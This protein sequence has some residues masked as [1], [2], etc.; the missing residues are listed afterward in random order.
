MLFLPCCSKP[1]YL[2]KLGVFH[3]SQDVVQKQ[4]KHCKLQ[5]KGLVMRKTCAK[6]CHGVERVARLL[7]AVAAVVAE[8]AVVRQAQKGAR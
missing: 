8:D 7:A 4:A 3:T 6:T 1:T 2:D 5:C